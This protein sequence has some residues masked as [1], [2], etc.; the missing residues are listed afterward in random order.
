MQE[1][2]NHNYK[3]FDEF[4]TEF[5][6][7]EFREEFG[8]VAHE[9]SLVSISE[10]AK[11]L[12]LFITKKK[13]I[14]IVEYRTLD[15]FHEE[16]QKRNT[17][18]EI[19]AN[20]LAI[21]NGESRIRPEVITAHKDPYSITFYIVKKGQPKRACNAHGFYDYKKK[22]FIIAAGSM[23]SLDV[24]PSYMCTSSNVQRIKFLSQYCEKRL[25]GYYVKVDVPCDSPSAA[26]CFVA[27][28]SA[29]G[30]VEWKDKI[31]RTL[32]EIFVVQ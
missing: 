15:I 28:C 1:L 4:E 21:A 24:A 31:G 3:I 8:K 9:I 17:L 22:K 5:L 11:R 14:K 25:N 6:K 20:L 12:S 16:E 32:K 13:P 10:Q 19:I 29:N 26:A 2:H 27:G 18:S 30:W 23:L 7:E